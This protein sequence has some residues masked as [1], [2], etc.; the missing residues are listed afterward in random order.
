LLPRRKHIKHTEKHRKTQKNTE[1]A[2]K[3]LIFVNKKVDRYQFLFIF[4]PE[5]HRAKT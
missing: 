1:T 4:V 3:K 2:H 5:L